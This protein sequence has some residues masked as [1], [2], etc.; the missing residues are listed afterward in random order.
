[1]HL[2]VLRK[3]GEQLQIHGGE[4]GDAEHEIA[5]RQARIGAG[6]R[7]HQRAP[8]LHTVRRALFTVVQMLPK[9][10]LPDLGVCAAAVRQLGDEFACRPCF[11]PV[12]AVH[13]ILVK[14]IGKLPRELIGGVIAVVQIRRK[15]LT[16]GGKIGRLR[17]L[18]GLK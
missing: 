15:S 8:Q 2:A 13:K 3:L 5:L 1:M 14:H 16:R 18:G 12:G 17:E 7:L 4:G 9:L 6:E 10:G 11:Y